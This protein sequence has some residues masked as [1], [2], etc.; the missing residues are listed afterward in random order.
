MALAEEDVQ[1]VHEEEENRQRPTIQPER[2]IASQ[3]S[4]RIKMQKYHL[5]QEQ[6]NR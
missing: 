4:Q 5:E 2:I 1:V 3:Q 6:I